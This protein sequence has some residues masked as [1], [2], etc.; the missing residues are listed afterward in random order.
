MYKYIGVG[1]MGLFVFM[2]FPSGMQNDTQEGLQMY[3]TATLDYQDESGNS[4]FTQ[5]VHNQLFDRGETELLEQVFA[6]GTTATID[7]VQIASMCIAEGTP[8]ASG[9]EDQDAAAFVT[10]N[11][12][13]GVETNCIEANFTINADETADSP[14]NVFISGTHLVSGDQV[15]SI[16]LCSGEASG[17][18]HAGCSGVL[19][20]VVDTSDVTLTGTESV[21]ITYTFDISSAGT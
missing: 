15:T 9:D 11:S 2:M 21:T 13:S 3:G 18:P 6:D 12:I 19:F 10:A 8:L 14:A 1:L 20:A 5:T 16:G 7:N 17:S 4:M